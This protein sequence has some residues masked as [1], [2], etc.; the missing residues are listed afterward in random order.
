MR[1]LRRFTDEFRYRQILIWLIVWVVIIVREGVVN[2][3][4]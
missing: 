4:M 2:G 3:D 1:K